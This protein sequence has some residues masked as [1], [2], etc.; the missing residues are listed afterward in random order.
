MVRGTMEGVVRLDV[1][2]VVDV[3]RGRNWAEA[4]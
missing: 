3:G 2:V 4:H 1:P